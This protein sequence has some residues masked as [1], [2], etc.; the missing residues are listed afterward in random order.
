MKGEVK[1]F[2]TLAAVYRCCAQ[3]KF[4]LQKRVPSSIGALLFLSSPVES[5]TK[6]CVELV[7]RWLRGLRSNVKQTCGSHP[8]TLRILGHLATVSH[9]NDR[10]VPFVDVRQHLPPTYR[11]ALVFEIGAPPYRRS[12]D[13][14]WKGS[15]LYLDIVQLEP[16]WQGNP[17]DADKF[18]YWGY[19]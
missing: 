11:E 19:R 8:L 12:V 6:P 1:P 2:C 18:T 17:A 16:Q 13:A 15:T 14:C 3:G 4:L 7:T 5:Y 9:N 10:V